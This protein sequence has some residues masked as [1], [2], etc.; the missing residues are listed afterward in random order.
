MELKYNNT[1]VAGIAAVAVLSLAWGVGVK[2]KTYGRGALSEIRS[3]KAARAAPGKR[4]SYDIRQES[5]VK[6]TALGEDSVVLE[7]VTT[8]P[9]PMAV[10]N[11]RNYFVGGRIGRFTLIDIGEDQVLL[12]DGNKTYELKTG[13]SLQGLE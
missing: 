9:R 6:T 3:K 4:L 10:F 5:S 11:G 12:D 1:V 13:R 8:S 7:A 2:I